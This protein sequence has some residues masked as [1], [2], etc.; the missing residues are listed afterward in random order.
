MERD[1]LTYKHY[2]ARVTYDAVEM[3]LR[4]RVEG[5]AEHVT[6]ESRKTDAVEAAFQQAVD[7]YLARCAREGRRPDREY[8]GCFNV[9]IHPSCHRE[10][11][12]LAFEHPWET[13][14]SL[15]ERAVKEFLEKP[16]QPAWES[17]KE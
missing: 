1:I 4:G 15:V 14:N 10:L 7:D 8:R 2:R 11:A 6:F 5:L 13:I 16:Y 9:R 17:D 3:V 12:M